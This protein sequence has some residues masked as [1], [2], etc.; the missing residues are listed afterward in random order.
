VEGETVEG[1]LVDILMVIARIAVV[2]Y[3]VP[4]YSFLY[5]LR[6]ERWDLLTAEVKRYGRTMEGN[7]SRKLFRKGPSE[8]YLAH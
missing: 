1:K 2:V 6:G 8:F 3:E 7:P 4:L 5:L